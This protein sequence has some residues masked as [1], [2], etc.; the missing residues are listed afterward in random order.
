MR[1]EI[2]SRINFCIFISHLRKMFDFR[3]VLS[4]L[5]TSSPC[6]AVYSATRPV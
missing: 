4:N 2:L 3:A 1:D 5:L 6:G